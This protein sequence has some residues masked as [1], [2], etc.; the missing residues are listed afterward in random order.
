MIIFPYQITIIIHLFEH[1]YTTYT[2][3]LDNLNCAQDSGW[4]W[5]MMTSS[6]GSIFR[7]SGLL[8]QHKGQWRGALMFSLICTWTDSWANNGDAGDLRR[9][10]ALY[11]LIVMVGLGGNVS[12]VKIESRRLASTN[13]AKFEAERRSYKCIPFLSRINNTS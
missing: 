9:Y 7:V 3:I 4:V 6:N 10:C 12:G 8:F 2:D 5:V 11:D 1:T 13:V